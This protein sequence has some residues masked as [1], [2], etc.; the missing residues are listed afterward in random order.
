M[1]N[2]VFDS[3]RSKLAINEALANKSFCIEFLNALVDFA[4]II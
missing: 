2:Y 1:S 4:L 3:N